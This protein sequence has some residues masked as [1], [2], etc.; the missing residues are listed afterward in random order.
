MYFFFYCKGKKGKYSSIE[1]VFLNYITI[2]MIAAFVDYD[3][4]K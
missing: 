2:N 1:N 4:L 3:I